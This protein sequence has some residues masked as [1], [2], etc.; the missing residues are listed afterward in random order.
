MEVCRK[1]G[2][3]PLAIHSVLQVLC[4]VNDHVVI[5][6]TPEYGVIDLQWFEHPADYH[7]KK[8]ADCAL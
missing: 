8:E 4:C 5:E 1:F 7:N 3:L 6:V 2:L